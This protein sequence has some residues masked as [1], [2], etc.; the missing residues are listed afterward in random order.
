[1]ILKQVI[2]YTNANAIEAT[3]TDSDGV[4]QL[5]K[6]YSDAQMSDFRADV[7]Q[8][9][10]DIAEYEALIAEVE[11]GIVPPPFATAA[12]VWESIKSI[13]D[14]KTQ[15]GGYKV[16]T[17]WFHSDTFSRTQ[18]IGLTIMGANMPAGIM[19]KTMAGSF[20]EM[21]PTLAQQIFAA[22]GAQDA[23][24]F[25]YAEQLRVQAYAIESQGQDPGTLDISVGWPATY[26]G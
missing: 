3:W 23:A 16:G 21:T 22:A 9:G 7:A 2:K 11:A 8:Y 19:W 20:V 6:A 14:T 17:D 4:V 5:C 13:R 18:Q 25:G 12:S 26:Q 1:M 24:L 15:Q 10:G